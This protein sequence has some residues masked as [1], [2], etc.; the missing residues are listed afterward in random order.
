MK[1]MKGINNPS[2]T[3]DSPSIN[4]RRSL[5]ENVQIENENKSIDEY[6]DHHHHHH[7]N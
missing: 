3:I 1:K 5:V 4:P 2:L 6:D 7:Y